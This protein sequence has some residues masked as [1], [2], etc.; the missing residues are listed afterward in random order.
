RV[1]RG[2]PRRLR[3]H[4]HGVIP[5][6]SECPRES[7]PGAFA[8]VRLATASKLASLSAQSRVV[9]A[10]PRRRAQ[11]PRGS[12]QARFPLGSIARE[13]AM[14][15][16]VWARGIGAEAFDLVLLVRL[17]VA[18]EPVPVRRVLRRSLVR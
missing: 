5:R 13:L 7:I 18:L 16:A 2:A 10:T 9:L 15:G 17:E 12:E 8:I 14:G 3:H 1:A 4:R 6:N 11:S